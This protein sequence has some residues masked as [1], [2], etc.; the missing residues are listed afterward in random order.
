MK[1]IITEDQFNK[2]QESDK[3]FNKTKKLVNSMFD[4][5]Y[6]VDD[7]LKITGLDK[8]A[9]I[10]LLYDREVIQDEIEDCQNKHDYLY[11]TLF[12][13]DSG[14]INKDRY[15][16]DGSSIE[17]TFDRFSGTID[18]H[19]KSEGY[20]LMGYATLM[21]DAEPK[22]PIDLTYFVDLDE[23]DYDIDGYYSSMVDLKTDSKFNNIKTL[24]QLVDYFNNDYY[25]MLKEELDP[26]LK[27]CKTDYL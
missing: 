26:L 10:V 2:L 24:R 3:E 18:V 25:I 20:H 23:T 6:D 15:F 12:R 7:I 17:I 13:G 9:V 5:G 1:I 27:Q 16:E 21:W 11:Y 22:L 19:Y 14:L 8:D 4:Q